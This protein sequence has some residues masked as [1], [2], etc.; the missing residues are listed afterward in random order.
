M[1]SFIFCPACLAHNKLG[2]ISQLRQKQEC[3]SCGMKFSKSATLIS[4]NTLRT[5]IKHSRDN[6]DYLLD[7]LEGM[8]KK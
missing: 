5:H 2:L 8:I 1:S 6:L 3:N 4:E 7:I